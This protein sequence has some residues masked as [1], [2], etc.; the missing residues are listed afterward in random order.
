MKKFFFTFI[1]F[2]FLVSISLI[3]ILSTVGIKTNKFNKII[4]KKINQSNNNINLELTIVKFRLD[5]KQISL[6]LE[7]NSPKL[8][9][10]DTII[11]V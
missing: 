8:N 1:S 5:I 11:P 4:E 10:K 7:T 6:F 3:T 9:F 2:V